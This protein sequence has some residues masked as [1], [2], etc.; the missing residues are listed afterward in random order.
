VRA[1][2][3]GL[4]RLTNVGASYYVLSG[5]YSPDGKSVV[6]ATDEGAT[7]NPHGNTFADIVTMG[8]DGGKLTYVTHAANLDGWPTW[9]TAQ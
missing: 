1:D 4:E 6:F 2:G 9:G 3:T 8:L 5:S 7:A